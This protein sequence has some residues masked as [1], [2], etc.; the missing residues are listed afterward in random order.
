MASKKE[1]L[2]A[3]AASWA[4][5]A[6]DATKKFFSAADGESEGGAEAAKS[7]NATKTTRGKAKA[8]EPVREA[9]K[10][11]EGVSKAE[12]VIFSVRADADAVA[13]WKSYAKAKTGATITAVVAA[14]MREYMAR[15]KLTDAETETYNR[16]MRKHELL[17]DL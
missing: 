17:K 5:A 14:A 1:R 8:V 13:E 10:A 11:P 7:A 4:D 2:E 12:A 6:A 9:S 16:E 3:A 15:H